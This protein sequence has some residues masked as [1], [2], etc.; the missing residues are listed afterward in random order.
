MPTRCVAELPHN[1]TRCLNGIRHAVLGAFGCGAFK[2]PAFEVA[3]FYREEI[4][5]RTGDFSVLAFA[6]FSAGYGP[7]NFTPFERTFS[8]TG[9]DQ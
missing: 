4:A 3:N 2:N 7:N 9:T 8:I 5:K 1:W 6:I